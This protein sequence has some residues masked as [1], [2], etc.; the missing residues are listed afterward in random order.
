[1]PFF[2]SFITLSGISPPLAGEIKERVYHEQCLFANF[3]Y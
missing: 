2:I 1:M 3:F